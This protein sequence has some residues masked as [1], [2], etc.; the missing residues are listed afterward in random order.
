M[1]K[2]EFK[3]IKFAYEKNII[4]DDLSLNVNDHEFLVI[5]GPSGSGKTTLLRI[6]AGFEKINGGKILYDGKELSMDDRKN[7]TAMVFQNYA[8]FSSMKVKDNI[9]YGLRNVKSKKNIKYE[10]VKSVADSLNIGSLIERYPSELSGGEKQRVGLARALIRNPKIYLFDEPLSNLDTSLKQTMRNE[11]KNIYNKSKGI[12]IYVTHDQIEASVLAT[13]LLVMSSNGVEQI[14][15]PKE[16]YNNPKN[17]FVASFFGDPK[18]NLLNG[19]IL[20]IGKNFYIEMLDNKFL[21][22]NKIYN[23]KLLD[24]YNK[25]NIIIGVRPED[26]IFDNNGLE[27]KLESIEYLGKYD[28]LNIDVNGNKITMI[29]YKKDNETKKINFKNLILFD[30]KTSENIFYKKYC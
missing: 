19:K 2:L 25:K 29:D 4:Y 17:I 20:K 14:G 28:V 24:N 12:F 15:S 23:Y 1:S 18:I 22:D 27:N 8:L 26:V 21:L 5:V 6:M 10:K 11:I 30:E 16:I 9:R 7:I 13:K 3:N